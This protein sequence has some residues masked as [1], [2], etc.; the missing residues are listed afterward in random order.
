M[1]LQISKSY[2]ETQVFDNFALEI[3]D[4]EVL[5]V[6]GASGV[7]KTTLLNILAGLTDCVGEKEGI[8][9]S[10]GYI[11]QEPRLLPNL[12]VKQNLFYTGANAE[13]IEEIL[14]AVDLLAKADKKPASL[15]G[16]EKQ[17]V[18]IARAFLSDAELLLLD[19]PFSSLDIALKIRLW[20]VFA[21]LWKQEKERKKRTAVLVTHDIE[22]AWALGQRIILLEKGRVALDIRPSGEEYPRAY[23]AASAEKERILRALLSEEIMQ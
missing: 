3:A 2:G 16:G 6:L 1:R 8:P 11:F 13:R 21:R 9:D 22:E 17:R 4:G 15:S 12:T 23:G 5:C 19:E 18:A 7:G 20:Q 14:Q 10:V